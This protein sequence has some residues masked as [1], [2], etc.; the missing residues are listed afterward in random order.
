MAISRTMVSKDE[1]MKKLNLE[2]KWANHAY[3]MELDEGMNERNYL[4]LLRLRA[5]VEE[6]QRLADIVNKLQTFQM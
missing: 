2:I 3:S 4:E 5:V 1:L 6:A